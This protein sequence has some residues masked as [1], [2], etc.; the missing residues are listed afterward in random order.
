MLLIV[1]LPAAWIAFSGFLVLLCRMAAMSDREQDSPG[2][3]VGPLQ[4]SSLE[5]ILGWDRTARP[6][7]AARLRSGALPSERVP[8]A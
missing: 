2:T 6:V 1:L 8:A 5:G 3:P 7:S 4:I